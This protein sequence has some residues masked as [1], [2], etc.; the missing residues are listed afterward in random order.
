MIWLRSLAVLVVSLHVLGAQEPSAPNQGSAKTWVGRNHEFEEYLKTAECVSREVLEPAK[1]A[2]CTLPPG[3]PIARMAWRLPDGPFRG[4]HE[5]YKTEIAVYELDKLLKLDMVPPSV[6]RQLQGEGAAQQWVEGVFAVRADESPK[7]P[8]KSEWENQLVR[9]TMFDNLI[10]NKDRSR[11]NMLRDARW[12]LILLDHSRAFGADAN[13]PHK[14]TRIDSAYWKRIE[15]LTQKQ[16]DA[17]LHEWL[18][19]SAIRTILVRRERMRVEI[20][21]LAR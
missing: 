16:L 20:K 14:M 17:T 13:L 7:E 11:G 19:E 18:D 9:M 4:F 5:R 21:L 15:D 1:A 10:G 3:G 2:R 12:N 6:L 8:Y